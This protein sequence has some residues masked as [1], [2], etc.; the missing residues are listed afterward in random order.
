MGCQTDA[1]GKTGGIQ[2]R[3]VSV[4]RM[5][6]ESRPSQLVTLQ[7]QTSTGEGMPQ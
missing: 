2:G 1:G 6:R 5:M 4:V 3:F 7:L